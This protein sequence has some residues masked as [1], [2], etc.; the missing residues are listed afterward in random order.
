MYDE[1]FAKD[2]NEYPYQVINDKESISKILKL[3]IKQS[4]YILILYILTFNI[5]L[6]SYHIFFTSQQHRY[7]KDYN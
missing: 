5:S 4:S 7:I 6:S 1:E 2:E 3:Y